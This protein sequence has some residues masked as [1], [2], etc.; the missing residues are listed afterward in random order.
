MGN[1]SDSRLLG[2][3]GERV[4]AEFLRS[5]KYSLIGVGYRTRLGEIDIIAEN[6]KYL[7]FVEVKLRKDAHFSTARESVDRRKQE[8]IKKCAMLWLASND[9]NK[10][11]RFDVI[12]IYAPNGE[13]TNEPVVNHIINAFEM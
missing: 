5:N 7:V 13:K 10:Q 1:I 12:E 8:K 6:R 4:A 3:W 11:I 2:K 9:T